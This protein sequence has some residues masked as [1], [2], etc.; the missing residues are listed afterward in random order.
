MLGTT[1]KIDRKLSEIE[2][3]I[4]RLRARIK[5]LDAKA[6]RYRIARDVIGELDPRPVEG[7]FGGQ[8]SLNGEDADDVTGAPTIPE[9]ILAVVSDHPNG[10]DSATIIQRLSEK[11]EVNTKSVLSILSR[12]KGQGELEKRGKDFFLP[13]NEEGPEVGAS[14]PSNSTA[15]EMGAN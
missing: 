12:M 3:E 13:K 6:E 2:D 4:G 8:Y 14:G 5:V 9:R 1:E 11:S 10:V 7:S 15:S